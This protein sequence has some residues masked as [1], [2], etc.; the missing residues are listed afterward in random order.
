MISEQERQ[1]SRRRLRPR[2]VHAP[3]AAPLQALRHR[4]HQH[5][6]EKQL[7][8]ASELPPAAPSCSGTRRSSNSRIARSTTS[9][10]WRQPFTSTPAT[11]LP[12][13]IPRSN[14]GR[15]SCHLGYVGGPNGGP[16][17]CRR[18]RWPAR[19]GRFSAW[20]HWVQD[21]QVSARRRR[22]A[23]RQSAGT[24]AAWPAEQRKAGRID[25]ATYIAAVLFTGL[26]SSLFHFG[27]DYYLL[28][29][30]QKPPAEKLIWHGRN[31][32]QLPTFGLHPVSLTPA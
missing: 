9:C 1:H 8:R 30:A 28:T 5:F 12:S 14:L 11:V 15:L 32:P 3:L 27:V 13:R 6:P 29:S 4:R 7:K 2:R 20:P 18:M 26:F 19:R 24:C 10:A 31:K 17:R 23:G 25:V 21:V 16:E 22:S